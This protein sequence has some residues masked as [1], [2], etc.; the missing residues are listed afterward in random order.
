MRMLFVGLLAA[1]L[2]AVS[3][4]GASA[5]GFQGGIRGAVKDA[6]GV[7]PGAELTLTNEATGIARSTNANPSGEYNFPNLAP[8][9]YTLRAAVQGYKSYQSAGLIVGTQQFLTLDIVLEIGALDESITVTGA[10]PLIETSNAST[11]T[12]LN[13]DTMATLPSQARTAFMMGATVP[14]VVP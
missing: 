4:N 5:Q 1:V 13:S 9:T 6:G 14:T 7:I 3:A 11:G 10:T 8:G 2:L 12:T